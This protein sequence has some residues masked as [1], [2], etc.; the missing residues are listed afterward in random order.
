ML[1]NNCNAKP[2]VNYIVD[3]MDSICDFNS[4]IDK[5]KIPINVSNIDDVKHV[6]VKDVLSIIDEIINTYCVKIEAINYIVDEHDKGNTH[7]VSKH[8]KQ[9]LV[10]RRHERCCFIKDLT[11]I[12]NKIE[13][14]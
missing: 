6:S 13:N 5:T 4:V 11:N 10:S 7:H 3:E 9:R 2:D 12:K 8:D 14:L 1:N